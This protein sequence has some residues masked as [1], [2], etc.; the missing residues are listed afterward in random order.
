MIS[1][2]SSM[3]VSVLVWSGARW[4]GVGAVRDTSGGTYPGT[5]AVAAYAI[6]LPTDSI[7][8]RNGL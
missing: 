7:S 6:F 5:A 3:V 4:V 1:R 8:K 2:S